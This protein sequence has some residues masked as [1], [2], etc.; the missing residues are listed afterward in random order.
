[1]VMKN[2]VANIA[3]F[4]KQVLF[5]R[6]VV[7]LAAGFVML[8]STACQPPTPV[9]SGEGSYH[10]KVGANQPTELYDPIEEREGGMNQYSDT[11]PRY[12]TGNLGNKIGGRVD[13]AKENLNRSIDSTEDYARNY[14]EG[15]PLGERVRNITDN[16]GKS[17]ENLT[18]EV[19]GGT[20]RGTRNL[21]VNADQAGQNANEAVSGATDNL[22]DSSRDITQK[23]KRVINDRA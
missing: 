18:D 9:S 5:Q 3:S 8:M 17:V 20:E 21:K 11:D 13:K 6:V 23:A 1:M 4:F 14:R 10:E 19:S 2:F 15:T 12:K 7:V 16:V 22:K